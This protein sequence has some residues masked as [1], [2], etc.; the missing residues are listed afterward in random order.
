MAFGHITALGRMHVMAFGHIM[1]F[2]YITAFGRQNPDQCFARDQAL[3][4]FLFLYM[5]FNYCTSTNYFVL[6][7]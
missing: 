6:K 7:K 2:G 5:L 4:I 3:F 1:A